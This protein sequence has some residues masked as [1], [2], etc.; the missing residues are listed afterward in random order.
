MYRQLHDDDTVTLSRACSIILLVV[1][2]AFLT[3]QLKTHAHL[4]EGEPKAQQGGGKMAERVGL[5]A[6]V[7][8]SADKEEAKREGEE[9]EEEEGVEEEEEEEDVLGFRGSIV[10]LGIITFLISILSEHIIDTI[11]GAAKSLHIPV[12]FV[13]TILLPIVGNAAVS[14]CRAVVWSARKASRVVLLQRAVLRNVAVNPFVNS[15]FGA[16]AQHGELA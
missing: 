4:F 16:N 12:A 10:W 1:Y 15:M 3:F 2:I 13:S 6:K 7:A 14:H 9:E 5:T 11:E 8:P